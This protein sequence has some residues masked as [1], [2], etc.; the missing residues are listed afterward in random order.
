MKQQ[1][2]ECGRAVNTHGVRGALRVE[3]YCDTPETLAK[4]KTVYLNR[5]GVFEPLKVVSSSVHKNSVLIYLEGIDTLEKAIVMKGTVLYADR[6]DFMLKRGDVFIA[7]L[8]G[9][10]VIDTAT[11]ETVGTLDEVI[12]PGGRDVYMVRNADGS[13]FMIP[14]VSEFI[15]E[16]RTEGDGEGIYVV[17][18]EGMRE[19]TCV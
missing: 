1:Y 15:K 10:P 18:I 14:A 3:S 7:D 2:L 6:S 11:G 12:S 16:I 19:N 4:L 17:L 5:D 9:L 13:R 8:I